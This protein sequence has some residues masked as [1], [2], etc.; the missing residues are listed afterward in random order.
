[1]ARYTLIRRLS[2]MTAAAGTAM[3]L[4]IASAGASTAQA[5]VAANVP[6][7]SVKLSAGG[8]SSGHSLTRLVETGVQTLASRPDPATRIPSGHSLTRLVEA[9]VPTPAP[10]RNPAIKIA[11]GH[12]LTRLVETGIQASS[13]PSVHRAA[14]GREGHATLIAARPVAF[15]VLGGLVLAGGCGLALR[16]RRTLHVV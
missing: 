11:S 10:H 4:V 14:L 13:P 9:G 1:M 2:C 7:S 12:S 3:L 6:A 8:P 5:A 15:G 16:R